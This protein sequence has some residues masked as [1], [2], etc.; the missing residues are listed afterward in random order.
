MFLTALQKGAI[1]RQTFESE[2]ITWRQFTATS[3]RL[4]KDCGGQPAIIMCNTLKTEK[5]NGEKESEAEDQ[6]CLCNPH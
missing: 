6:N 1:Q 2:T 4:H 5:R 3:H